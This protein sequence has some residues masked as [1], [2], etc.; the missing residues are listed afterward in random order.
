MKVAHINVTCGKGSTGVIV[1]E[2]SERL[3]EK[4]HQSFIA[5]GLDKSDYPNSFK[6]GSKLEAKLHALFNT[7]I[8]GEEGTGSIRATKKLV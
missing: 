8:M 2:I 7:R 6:I 1:V 4:G 5:Y 3:K